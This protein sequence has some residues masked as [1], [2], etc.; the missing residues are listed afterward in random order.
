[1]SSGLDREEWRRV[2]GVIGDG[3]F[4]GVV[5]GA[6]D[7]NDVTYERYIAKTR[8]DPIVGRGIG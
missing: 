1:M 2:G 6:V 8:A 5:M 3:S 7:K 4:F